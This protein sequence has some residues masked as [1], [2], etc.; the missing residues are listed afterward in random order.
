MLRILKIRLKKSFVAQLRYA[1]ICFQKR[2]G[3]KVFGVMGI[4]EGI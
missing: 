4:P 2:F 1:L 3:N